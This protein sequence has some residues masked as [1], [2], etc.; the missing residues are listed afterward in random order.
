MLLKQHVLVTC[1]K[2][3]QYYMWIVKNFLQTDL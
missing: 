1:Q 3:Y 2:T